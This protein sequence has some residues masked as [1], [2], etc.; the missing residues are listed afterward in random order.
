MLEIN[1]KVLVDP[2]LLAPINEARNNQL[3][4]T[5]EQWARTAL[6]YALDRIAKL[7][8]L[9]LE[10][11]KTI[12]DLRTQIEGALSRIS[13]IESDEIN[14]DAVDNSLITLV[15]SLSSQITTWTQRIEQAETALSSIT[16]RVTT[17]ES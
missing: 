11:S 5:W 1:G 14:D 10:D 13:T 6:G 17:L 8:A 3:Y 7:E 2:D 15:G 16:D 12:A 4:Q 9:R